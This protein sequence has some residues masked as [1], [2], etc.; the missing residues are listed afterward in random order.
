MRSLLSLIVKVTVELQDRV[1]SMYL[2]TSQRCHYMFTMRD[3]SV[4]FKL[5]PFISTSVGR[6]LIL[7]EYLI[8]WF[9]CSVCNQKNM[10]LQALNIGNI[11]CISCSIMQIS[12]LPISLGIYSIFLYQYADFYHLTWLIEN[13]IDIFDLCFRNLCLSL[14]PGCSKRNLMLL[15]QHECTWVYSHR[16]VSEV[17]VRRYRQAFVTAVK[18]E[19]T[20]DEEVP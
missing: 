13:A 11:L 5:V 19:F 18:K 7:L 20:N 1:R 16:M 17:D 6:Y 12:I 2:T 9:H 3:L 15:W 4:I 8:L 10:K 14:R